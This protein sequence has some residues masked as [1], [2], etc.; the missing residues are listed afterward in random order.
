MKMPV[1]ILYS[2]ER[3]NGGAFNPNFVIKPFLYHRKK[4]AWASGLKYGLGFDVFNPIEHN[5]FK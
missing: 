3:K 2:M 1:A 5:V 4:I